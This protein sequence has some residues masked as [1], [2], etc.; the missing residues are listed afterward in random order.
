MN[1]WLTPVV[2]TYKQ[3]FGLSE[4]PVVWDVGSRD[5]RDGVELAQRISENYDEFTP[6]NAEIVCIEPNPDQADII[7]ENYSFVDVLELAVS[8]KRGK[9]SFMV[10][11]GD[12]GAV[13]SSSLDLEWKEDDLDGHIITVKTEQLKNLIADEMIDIM[14][15]DVEGYSMQALR[16]LGS[17]IYQIRVM[18]I[19]TE[20]WTGSDEEVK[21]Y[22]AKH[23]FVLT[24]ERQEWSGM[25]DLTYANASLAVHS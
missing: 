21:E 2:E 20:D 25:P 14:K 8:N 4:K 7:R 12:D 24:D 3:H 16:G 11:E 5:G 18:H 23:G 6:Y 17:K 1:E 13:G 15:I 10:Y 19:E 9:A 22:M